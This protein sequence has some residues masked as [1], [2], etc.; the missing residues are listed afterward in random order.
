MSNFGWGLLLVVV[1]IVLMFAMPREEMGY[2]NMLDAANCKANVEVAP[3]SVDTFFKSFTCRDNTPGERNCYYLK[4]E[5][6]VCVKSYYYH[7]N[8]SD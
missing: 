6:G 5:N 3:Y 1:V 4:T 2:I 7:R 8:L